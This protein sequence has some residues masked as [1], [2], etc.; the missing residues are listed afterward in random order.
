LQD[1][2]TSD[3]IR[4]QAEEL[5]ATAES[6]KLRRLFSKFQ[7]KTTERLSVDATTEIM[8]TLNHRIHVDDLLV[9][10]EKSNAKGPANEAVEHGF[11]PPERI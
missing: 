7:K 10:A 4:H 2:A 11:K 5:G 1:Y 9:A 3:L 8:K 6:A